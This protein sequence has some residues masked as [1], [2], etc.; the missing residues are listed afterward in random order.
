MRRWMQFAVDRRRSSSSAACRCRGSPRASARRRSTPT[1]AAR[2]T[3]RVAELRAASAARGP[4][5]LRDEGE[6]DAGARVPHGAAASTASTSRRAR[7]LQRRARRGRRSR[8]DQLRRPGQ[9]RGRARA[10]RCRRHPASTSSRRARSSSSRAIARALQLPARVAVRVNPD[11]ELKA[12]GMKMG[13]GPKQFGVD[14]EAVPALLRRD[15]RTR[16]RPSRAS[17]STAVRRT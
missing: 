1:T 8:R 2:S 6:S 7:E 3:E 16:A 9:D 10:G 13:G 15:R 14:A 12:S 17:T 11:F 4:A 5:A